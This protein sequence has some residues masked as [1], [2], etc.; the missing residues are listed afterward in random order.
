MQRTKTIR[1]KNRNKIICN[2]IAYYNFK[3]Y[4]SHTKQNMA[5]DFPI[6]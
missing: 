1:I 4:S 2:I 5:L 3:N 6:L